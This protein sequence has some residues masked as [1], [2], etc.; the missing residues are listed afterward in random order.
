MVRT[1]ALVQTTTLF[2]EYIIMWFNIVF[3]LFLSMYLVNDKSITF[4]GIIFNS[5]FLY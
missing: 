3:F 4:V 2:F 5:I 1:P